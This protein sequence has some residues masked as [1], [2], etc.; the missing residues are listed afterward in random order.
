M[1]KIVILMCL[2]LGS[3][4]SH[5]GAMLSLTESDIQKRL[6]LLLEFEIDILKKPSPGT[7]YHV[8][9]V[10]MD[11][12]TP[13]F[14]AACAVGAGAVPK[15]N[16]KE[17]FDTLIV[18]KATYKSTSDNKVNLEL[19]YKIDNG[20]TASPTK[21][22]V[23]LS[24]PTEVSSLISLPYEGKGKKLV[25]LSEESPLAS[26]L[27]SDRDLGIFDVFTVETRYCGEDPGEI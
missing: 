3:S 7:F 20:T 2:I 11:S 21:F 25:T 17:A 23:V 15:K 22:L 8:E 10:L 9:G 4:N 1:K 24:A 18:E 13:G 27:V 14:Y 16:M 12:V 26:L 19:I 6:N 5:A